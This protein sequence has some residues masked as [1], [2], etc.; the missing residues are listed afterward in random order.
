MANI[1]IGTLFPRYWH[2]RIHEDARHAA[3]VDYTHQMGSVLIA[4]RNAF[5]QLSHAP[6]LEEGVVDT[7]VRGGDTD[8]NAAIAGALLGAV[9]GRKDVPPRWRDTL[10]CCRPLPGTPTAH[11]QPSE[12]WPIDVMEIAEALLVA[13][14]S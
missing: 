8:T 1:T 3:P 14:R 13:A 11:P 2:A 9:Y 12:F 6:N 7:V 10:L 5:Y 4:L